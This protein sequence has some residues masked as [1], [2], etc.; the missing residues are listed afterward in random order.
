MWGFWRGAM[1]PAEFVLQPPPPLKLGKPRCCRA[2]L[3]T[4]M[5]PLDRRLG[6]PA[7]GIGCDPADSGATLNNGGLSLRIRRSWAVLNNS[8]LRPHQLELL[9]LLKQTLTK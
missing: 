3:A 1:I 6:G 4:S 8:G 7:K 5:Q 2:E 9:R